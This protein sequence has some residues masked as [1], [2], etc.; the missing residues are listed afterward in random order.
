MVELLLDQEQLPD[1]IWKKIH[2]TTVDCAGDCGGMDG[3]AGTGDEAYFDDCGLC[4]GGQSPNEPNSDKDCL[5][6]C[7]GGT[8]IDDCGVCGGDGGQIYSISHHD[9]VF[10]SDISVNSNTYLAS[11]YHTGAYDEQLKGFSWFQNGGGGIY[12]FNV[13]DQEDLEIGDEIQSIWITADSSAWTVYYNSDTPLAGFQF[14]IIGGGIAAAF[15]GA[16]EEA[17]FTVNISETTVIG[18]SLTG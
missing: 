7:F 14:D 6:I 2:T 10:E 17:G 3:I 4:V 1:S 18:F 16:A 11:E 12:E 15:G 9:D 8:L 13:W 5:G